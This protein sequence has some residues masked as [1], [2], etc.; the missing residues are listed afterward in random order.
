MRSQILNIVHWVK[1]TRIQVISSLLTARRLAIPK[2]D[3][4]KGLEQQILCPD[5]VR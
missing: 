3:S 2:P 4:T 1:Q 5:G